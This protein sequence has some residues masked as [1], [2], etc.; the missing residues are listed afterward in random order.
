MGQSYRPSLANRN[1]RLP[2]TVICYKFAHMAT[3]DERIGGNLRRFRERDGQSQAELA[4]RMTAAGHPWQQSTVARTEGG[5]QP[6]RA[7]EMETLAKM[8]RVEVDEFFSHVGEAAEQELVQG[9]HN[10][11]RDSTVD[12]VEAVTQFH[13]ARA[14]ARRTARDAASSEYA[15]VREAAESLDEELLHATLENVLVAANARW[16]ELRGKLDPADAAQSPGEDNSASRAKAMRA[17]AALYGHATTAAVT[18]K[19]LAYLTQGMPP[20]MVDEVVAAVAEVAEREENGTVLRRIRQAGLERL[21]AEGLAAELSRRSAKGVPPREM[22]EFL[23][24]AFRSVRGAEPAGTSA[25]KAVLD[26]IDGGGTSMLELANLLVA[27]MPPEEL[28]PFIP[29]RRR[30]FDELARGHDRRLRETRP[31]PVL[32]VVGEKNGA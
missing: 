30:S 1:R 12:A 18:P 15:H 2:S 22:D 16:E 5:Q 32:P 19:I 21:A 8:F 29:L 26:Y 13:G 7:A 4:R 31:Q 3:A 6:L 17:T 24:I 27:K 11:L 9:A 14:G 10:R 25:R 28:P 23:S 20:G